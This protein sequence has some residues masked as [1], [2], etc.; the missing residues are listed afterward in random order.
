[1]EAVVEN[2][3]VVGMTKPIINKNIFSDNNIK[4]YD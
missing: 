3:I 1:M 4:F 2:N